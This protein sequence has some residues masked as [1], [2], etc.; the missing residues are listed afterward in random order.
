MTMSKQ[1]LEAQK[2]VN[3]AHQAEIRSEEGLKRAQSMAQ[4]ATDLRVAVEKV[5]AGLVLARR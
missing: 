3:Q 1:L 4:E 2:A 5:I